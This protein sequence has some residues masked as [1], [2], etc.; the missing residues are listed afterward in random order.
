M[1]DFNK[2]AYIS[3]K[4]PKFLKHVF[5]SMLRKFLVSFPRMADI[6]YSIIGRDGMFVVL[7][8]V[9]MGK[10]V[11]RKMRLHNYLRQE[12]LKE[13]KKWVLESEK[14]EN[15]LFSNVY[16]LSKGG[17]YTL[18]F[19]QVA[20]YQFKNALIRPYSE[21][22]RLDDGVYWDK[23]SKPQLPM[24]IPMDRD[25]V[26]YDDRRALLIESPPRVFVKCGLSLLDLKIRSW[27]HFIACGLP[28]IKSLEK[29][30]EQNLEVLIPS[31]VDSHIKEIAENLSAEYGCYKVRY[32]DPNV[33]VHCESLYYCSA[34][35]FFADHALFV[36][37]AFAVVRDYSK[38][39]IFDGVKL[40]LKD[41]IRKEKRKLFVA[42]SGDRNVLGYEKIEKYFSAL[43]FEIVH[44]HKLSLSQKIQKFAEATHVV[45]PASSG[46][47]NL[48]F[49]NRGTKALILS[50]FSR[51]L[52]LS[53]ELYSNPR[54]FGIDLM[55]LTG[56][57]LK[58]GNPHSEFEVEIS[59]IQKCMND[60]N[61]F[62]YN[63]VMEDFCHP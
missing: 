59:R 25:L 31:N 20:L 27:G 56:I 12:K 1:S 51:T 6:V 16:G 54:Y 29:I 57:D 24:I 38:T 39:A 18:W 44:P 23:I 17:E 13:C 19:D 41:V 15:I 3:K 7:K 35:S 4:S 50:N 60:I 36:H 53:F 58:P 11:S 62:G 28:R 14:Y 42:R 37:P 34:P 40:L 32:V 22:V 5:V 49:C 21:F 43:G 55:L 52:E 63:T 2:V 46:F 48:I 61:F 10:I 33:T 9:P 30:N 47:V 8:N 26:A 45:G